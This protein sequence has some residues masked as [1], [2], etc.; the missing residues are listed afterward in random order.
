V[1][2]AL[3]LCWSAPPEAG[4]LTGHEALALVAKLA[5]GER[6][7]TDEALEEFA[8]AGPRAADHR[9]GA[10]EALGAAGSAARGA[11]P[12]LKALAETDPARAVRNAAAEAVKKVEAK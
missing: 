12:K 9:R 2:A 10:C 6:G 11:R 1:F 8:A 4:P 3:L 7:A 5:S